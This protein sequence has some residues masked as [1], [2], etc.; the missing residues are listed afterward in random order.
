LWSGARSMMGREFGAWQPRPIS[1]RWHLGTSHRTQPLAALRNDLALRACSLFTSLAH[2]D[3]CQ[4]RRP[5]PPLERLRSRV[6]LYNPSPTNPGRLLNFEVCKMAPATQQIS[7][8]GQS[9]S[10]CTRTPTLAGTT[11]PFLETDVTNACANRT[12]GQRA[13]Q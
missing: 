6:L 12:P 5:A 2:A 13:R 7:L 1:A 3:I 9:P 4:P 11:S 10:L 8:R